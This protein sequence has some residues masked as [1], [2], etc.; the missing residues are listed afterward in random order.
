MDEDTYNKRRLFRIL[1]W[2]MIGLYLVLNVGVLV[3]NTPLSLLVIILPLINIV[4]IGGW[5]LL[6][7]FF[8]NS[9]DKIKHHEYLESRPIDTPP[10]QYGQPSGSTYVPDVTIK[11]E[12]FVT[13]EQD[14][15]KPQSFDAS[16]QDYLKPGRII[17]FHNE[18]NYGSVL[19]VR[20]D[21]VVRRENI[22]EVSFK[23]PK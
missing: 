18:L 23:K 9:N 11:S 6:R 2:V 16:L 15:T 7:A 20:V 4:I 19:N 17:V 12:L 21:K 8:N 10:P 5:F 14:P 22:L 1:S 3:L 13:I